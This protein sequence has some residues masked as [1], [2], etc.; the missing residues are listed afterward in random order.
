MIIIQLAGGLGNQL[1]QYALYQKFKSLGAE[2]KLDLSW[3]EQF[4][5]I[6]QETNDKEQYK[7]QNKNYH[8]TNKTKPAIKQ[9]IVVTNR[10]CELDFFKHLP[11]ESCTEEEKTALTGSRG[12]AG[13]LRR[14]ML[15]QTVHWYKE[16]QMYDPELLHYREMYLSGY[17]ACEK[18]Y[19]D[20]L[21][22]LR[23]M[24]RFPE[25]AD[26]QKRIANE[27]IL[28]K[29]R[30]SHAVSVHIRRG[31]YLQ[32]EN[33]A[34]FG[35]ICTEEYY[36]SALDY[37]KEKIEDPHFFI[38][39]DDTAYVREHYQ[40]EKYTIV[41][42]NHGDDSFYDMYLM[43]RCEGNIC[44]N[45]TFSFWGARLNARPDKIMIRPTVQKNSQAFDEAQMKDLWKSWIFIDPQG[46]VYN[47]ITKN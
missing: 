33:A 19:A 26:A 13:K 43:S 3:F 18:Y 23:E 42:I 28:K 5:D 24:I 38:F 32:P 47:D 14:K 41:D 29:I 2:A 8:G 16:K 6:K 20:I 35:N 17:F 12:L 27:E 34:M 21:P 36:E 22:E 37:M 44:A 31:D 1:Q 30:N 7:E 11:Y 10:Q 25:I 4:E 39:S 9:D 40:G 46:Q 15:P 45:S